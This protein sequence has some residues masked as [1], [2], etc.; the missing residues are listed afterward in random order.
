[1]NVLWAQ[2]GSVSGK[3][4]EGGLTLTLNNERTVDIFN[5]YFGLVADAGSYVMDSEKNGQYSVEI[6]F[7]EGRSALL[8]FSLISM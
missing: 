5:K 1:M 4:S 7:G 2:G 8:D 3:D 6:M